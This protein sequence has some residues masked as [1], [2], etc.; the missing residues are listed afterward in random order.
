M[1]SCGNVRPASC[2]P[3]QCSFHCPGI[4]VLRPGLR[5]TDPC[6]TAVGREAYS[7]PVIN[8]REKLCTRLNNCYCNQDLHKTRFSIVSPRNASI[9]RCHPLTHPRTSFHD[10]APKHYLEALTAHKACGRHINQVAWIAQFEKCRK[11][12]AHCIGRV[13]HAGLGA[14]HCRGHALRWVSCY[15]LLGGY[16]PSWPPPHYQ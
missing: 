16:Q 14:I 11:R 10:T 3:N 13:N 8:H 4:A 9:S 2:S 15:T 1:P 5:P 6:A 7:T 12:M